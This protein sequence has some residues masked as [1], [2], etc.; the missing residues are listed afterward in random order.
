MRLK[1]RTKPVW[2]CA[3]LI[4]TAVITTVGVSPV[5]AEQPVREVSA[6]GTQ[7]AT[8]SWPCSGPDD[9][10]FRHRNYAQ[11][12][13]Y[14]VPP[15]VPLFRF[16]LGRNC[17]LPGTNAE[18]NIRIR[19][20]GHPIIPDRVECIAPGQ[21]VHLGFTG[22]S[23]TTPNPNAYKFALPAALGGCE[24]LPW[25]LPNT[26]PWDGTG[27]PW[28]P[29]PPAPCPTQAPDAPWC[30]P[31]CPDT[32]SPT[33]VCDADPVTVTAAGK[34]E[35]WRNDGGSD[36]RGLSG[37]KF[38]AVYHDGDQWQPLTDG[39]GG[40]GNRIVNHLGQDGGYSITFPYPN[41]YRLP[42]GDWWQGCPV[43]GDGV[44][45][46]GAHA[47]RAS[48]I[49]IRVYPE[50]EDRSILVLPPDS[51][52]TEYAWDAHIGRF[53]AEAA[54]PQQHIASS[55]AALA[56]GGTVN[57]LDLVGAETLGQTRIRLHDGDGTSHYSQSTRTV[58]LYADDSGRSTTE[59]ELGHQV[60]HNIFGAIPPAP[61][62]NPHEFQSPSS[63]R[64]AFQ[65]ALAHTVAAAS[66]N[67][68][69]EFS[70]TVITIG[71]GFDYDLE[72]CEIKH[73]SGLVVRCSTA[74]PAARNAE[75]WVAG[76]FVDLLDNTPTESLDGLPD[77]VRY[78]FK[79][80]FLPVLA[81]AKPT[82]FDEFW[83]AWQRK[84]GSKVNDAQV[85][86]LNHQVY[87]SKKDV[88][89]TSGSGWTSFD[90]SCVDRSGRILKPGA[91]GDPSATWT[92]THN[93]DPK[94]QYHIW[95]NNPSTTQADRDPSSRFTLNSSAGNH[96]FTLNQNTQ[97]GWT[98]L[99]GSTPVK[100]LSGDS[101]VLRSGSSPAKSIAADGVIIVPAP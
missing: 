80:H 71:D 20:W 78:S 64:C 13:E 4:A 45:F 21:V 93:V 6:A 25:D 60:H 35:V 70:R 50:N 30:L 96:T 88:S 65:E 86:F 81:E 12:P 82:T 22:G 44:E 84:F 74:D 79:H 63:P 95:V 39:P 99:N 15:G 55:P 62:C 27:G 31:L 26:E 52:A 38:E 28:A 47:C 18:L 11:S 51:D 66:E 83:V 2:L 49:A 76:T 48:D 19:H 53:F 36:T 58:T 29:A 57:V 41:R 56:Y 92:F 3:V 73:T 9:R 67:R 59:H 72:K 85:V 69:G 61:N 89:Y 10:G 77:L 37:A 54:G 91:A 94:K 75:G 97:P 34:V 46:A 32:V 8:T 33:N 40:T 87:S 100:I 7:N 42:S 14:P 24:N 17:N 23:I 16:S 5:S 98:L 90:C 1:R 43:P 68:P 101:L